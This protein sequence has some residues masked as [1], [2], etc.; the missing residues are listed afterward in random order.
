MP[1]SL[2]RCLFFGG[3]RRKEPSRFR[4]SAS[5]RRARSLS[6]DTA[7]LDEDSGACGATI[8]SS[9]HVRRVHFREPSHVK[10]AL[11]SLSSFR[12]AAA[13]NGYYAS[14]SSTTFSQF[15]TIHFVCWNAFDEFPTLVSDYFQECGRATGRM[16]LHLSLTD[17]CRMEPISTAAL[18]QFLNSIDPHQLQSLRLCD[19]WLMGDSQPLAQALRR[20]EQLTSFSCIE[21][22]FS[23][24]A[25]TDPVPIAQ[26]LS[27]LPNL[28]G[29]SFDFQ[30]SQI[31]KESV[32]IMTRYF[33]QMNLQSSSG[34]ERLALVDLPYGVDLVAFVETT[35]HER[36][37]WEHEG[38]TKTE[39]S[40]VSPKRTMVTTTTTTLTLRSLRLG[41]LSPKNTTYVTQ[42]LQAN[43][44]VLEELTLMVERCISL[45][46]FAVALETNTHL[47][48]LSVSSAGRSSTALEHKEM[49]AFLTLLEDRHNYTLEQLF[50]PW[51]TEVLRFPEQDAIGSD[52]IRQ[53]LFYLQLNRDFDRKRLLDTISTRHDSAND[54]FNSIS[55]NEWTDFMGS[56]SSSFPSS[57]AAEKDSMLASVLFYYLSKHPSLLLM[58]ATTNAADIA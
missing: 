37:L 11:L 16:H 22:R 21:C 33:A 1:L 48:V 57:P 25:T 28:Q 7:Y 55:V 32:Q 13:M 38:A 53:L 17:R 35:M 52:Y 18:A 24:T 50:T 31:S 58:G 42:L 29:I 26:V 30:Y 20:H 41:T 56:L 5:T 8:R 49:E 43:L 9:P 2:G 12:K 40:L 15:V 6:R 19:I 45:V 36:S 54:H 14:S 39:V 3:C 46:Q 51:M 4:Q 47:K 10:Q 34:L 27:T 23:T 44:P